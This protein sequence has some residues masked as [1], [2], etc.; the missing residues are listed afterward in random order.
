MCIYLRG[1]EDVLD[2]HEVGDVPGVLSER[3]QRKTII[4]HK[5]WSRQKETREICFQPLNH[6]L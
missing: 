1:V 4:S 2:L 6:R 5:H 3:A